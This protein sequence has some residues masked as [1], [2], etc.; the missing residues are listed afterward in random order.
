MKSATKHEMADTNGF[1]DVK[2][3]NSTVAG[4]Y[5]GMLCNQSLDERQYDD[6]LFRERALS[7]SVKDFQN[8]FVHIY[9]WILWVW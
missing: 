4:F 1:A 8:Y 7:V 9:R 2:V 3:L 5:S 6:V